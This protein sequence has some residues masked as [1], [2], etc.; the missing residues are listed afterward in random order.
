ML[1]VLTQQIVRLHH[2]ISWVETRQRHSLLQHRVLLEVILLQLRLRRYWKRERIGGVLL[3]L[4][5]RRRTKVQALLV[6]NLLNV[7]WL[8]LAI[9][10]DAD[11]IILR[12]ETRGPQRRIVVG[13]KVGLLAS[14][15][16]LE[17]VV[18]K[19][20]ANLVVVSLGW[21]MIKGNVQST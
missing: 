11:W 9:A 21:R 18:V 3:A 13:C 14:V 1:L 16:I 7:G 17:G 10:W 5:Q 15:S 6:E 19:V 2:K 4:N 20:L 8:R 12:T